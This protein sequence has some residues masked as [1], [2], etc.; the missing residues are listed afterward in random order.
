[1]GLTALTLAVA[2]SV[3]RLAHQAFR[4]RLEKKGMHGA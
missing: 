2:F 1:L 3:A 4:R